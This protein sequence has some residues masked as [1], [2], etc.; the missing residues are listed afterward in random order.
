LRRQPAEGRAR[1]RDRPRP[2]GPDRGAADAG[3]RRRRDRVRPPPLDLR[4]RRGPW[5]A[6]RLARARRDLLALR[7][8]PRHVRG[9]SRRR[10]LPERLG[11]HDRARDDR[12]HTRG[13]C[14]GMTEAALPPPPGESG[15]PP[16]AEQPVPEEGKRFNS[17]GLIVSIITTA[18]AFL[19]GGLVVLAT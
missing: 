6:A 14:Y 15:I 1:P 3:P 4:A 7:P 8:H 2:E 12:R 11:G 16:V 13:G 17:Q 18:L 19:V 10:V 5:R 9:S